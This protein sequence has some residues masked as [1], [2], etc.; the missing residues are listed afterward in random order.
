MRGD[1]REEGKRVEEEE[2]TRGRA[3]RRHGGRGESKNRTERGREGERRGGGEEEG[4]TG[5]TSGVSPF[6]LTFGTLN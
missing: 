6:R 5:T 3:G 4:G 2:E 1:W